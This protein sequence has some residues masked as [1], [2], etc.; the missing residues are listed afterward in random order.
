MMT[1]TASS[2][3]FIDGHAFQTSHGPARPLFQ[4]LSPRPNGLPHEQ[5][6]SHQRERLC[7]AMVA[8]AAEKG[9][10]RVTV[11]ELCLLAGVSKRTFY[12]IFSSKQ[13]C[14]AAAHERV[15][16]HA[17]QRMRRAP[18]VEGW[19]QESLEAA[20]TALLAEA[21]R[22]P[23]AA[24][25]ALLEAIDATSAALE[26][27]G[28]AALQIQRE[29]AH[30]LRCAENAPVSPL[31]L[32]GIVAGLSHVICARLIDDR[33]ADLPLLAPD[34]TGWALSCVALLP[35]AEPQAVAEVH[36]L[37]AGV[38]CHRD[39][40]LR[41]TGKL[42]AQRNDRALLMESALVLV[43]EGGRL[44]L[45]PESLANH[46]G[47]PARRLHALFGDEQQCL[48]EAIRDGG[49]QLLEDAI[50]VAMQQREWQRRLHAGLLALL[51]G[52][53]M[54][55]ALAQA[56]FVESFSFGV[57]AHAVRAELIA[58]AAQMLRQAIPIDAEPSRVVCEASVAAIAGLIAT[59]VADF[60]PSHVGEL[61]THAEALLL[62]PTLSVPAFG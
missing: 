57:R 27:Q 2:N 32:R 43:A 16:C 22:R 61:A 26:R 15:V 44:R 38:G 62:A 54:Q 56:L 33:A 36:L 52:L 55:P 58:R 34:L 29:I 37:R 6:V 7:R 40:R 21:M 5:V 59:H 28:W 17:A 12:E 60:G 20:L 47:V 31:V 9:S 25:F 4:K 3:S 51:T 14:L 23:E 48:H 46:S 10:E 50:G 24:R 39:R 1:E 35:T 18:H 30:R 41:Q 49:A 11:G 42:F 53:R 13:E 8:A 19:P 45:C